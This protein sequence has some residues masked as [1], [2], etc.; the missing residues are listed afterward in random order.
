MP[1]STTRIQAGAT[2]SALSSDHDTTQLEDKVTFIARVS[3][4]A[5]SGKAT[6]AG[7]VQFT[8]DGAD[9][10]KPFELDSYGRAALTTT[11]LSEGQHQVLAR[12][13]PAEKSAFLASVSFELAHSVV[14]RSHDSE[15]R[16]GT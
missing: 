8:I 5:S 4:R 10:G 1:I 2:T 7:S 15:T 14:C 3:R 9:V 12:Y 6:P 13:V 16:P 11:H